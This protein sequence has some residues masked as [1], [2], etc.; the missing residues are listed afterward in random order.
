MCNM[1]P[2]PEAMANDMMKGFFDADFAS[3]VIPLMGELDLLHLGFRQSA[4][5]VE[6]VLRILRAQ[7]FLDVLSAITLLMNPS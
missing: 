5:S 3:T 6:R 4:L 2:D 1:F 7:G